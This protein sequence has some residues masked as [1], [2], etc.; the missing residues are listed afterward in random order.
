[1]LEL[2]YSGELIIGEKEF[3][4]PELISMKDF[5]QNNPYHPEG[6]LMNHTQQVLKLLG[7]DNRDLWLAGVF[8]DIGKQT[9]WQIS[10]KNKNYKTFYGHDRE[11]A[12]LFLKF[13]K[14][15]NFNDLNFN[16]EKVHW[17]IY[18]H[19]KIMFY[20]KMREIKKIT[21]NTSPWFEDLKKFR[22]CDE[23]GRHD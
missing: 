12:K 6:N 19:I 8:H 9:R 7:K 13:N 4:I 2:K 18:N 16:V 15:H 17:I 14:E 21:L 1:M 23:G 3:I 5:E 20:D 10:K 11:S 22:Q